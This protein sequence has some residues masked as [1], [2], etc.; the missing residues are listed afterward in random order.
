MTDDIMPQCCGLISFYSFFISAVRYHSIACLFRIIEIK[1]KEEASNLLG[2]F[3]ILS[4]FGIKKICM[5]EFFLTNI[6]RLTQHFQSFILRPP[7]LLCTL[8]PSVFCSLS[9]RLAP[10]IF[11]SVLV[12]PSCCSARLLC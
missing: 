1:M 3:Q 10:S 8:K 2:G 4:L 11:T 7:P 12:S 9:L 6:L 5:F